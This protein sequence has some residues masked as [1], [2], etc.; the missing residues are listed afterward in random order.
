M[1][2]GVATRGGTGQTRETDENIA[3]LFNTR[4]R[5]RII[6]YLLG[7]A[8]RAPGRCLLKPGGGD[9]D[10]DGE[11]SLWEFDK[12]EWKRRKHRK[13]GDGIKR[14]FSKVDL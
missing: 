2:N 7:L 12:R 4:I 1:A 9:D 10:D 6:Y 8:P 14:L 3:C 13:L 11:V 5:I